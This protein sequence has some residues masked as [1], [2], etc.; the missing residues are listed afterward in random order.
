[1]VDH[2]LLKQESTWNDIK[3]L[4]DDAIKYKVAAACIPPC[5]VKMA[6]E[7]VKGKIKICTVIGFPNGNNT[8]QTKVWETANK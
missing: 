5:Y 3:V 7:Y 2:T 8:I 4:L 1:M 6:K